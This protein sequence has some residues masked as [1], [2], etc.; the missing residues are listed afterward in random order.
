MSHDRPLRFNAFVMNTNSHIQHGHWRRPDAGQVD[1]EDV[2]L[3]I[4]LAKTLEAAT[5]STSATVCRFPAT[6]RPSS[7]AP[8]QL[9]PSTWVSR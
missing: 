8:S 2:N 7:S 3:W 5:R 6:T 4:D 1:F 9:S